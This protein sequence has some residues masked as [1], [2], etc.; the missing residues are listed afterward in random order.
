MGITTVGRRIRR[1]SGGITTKGSIGRSS[2]STAASI[3]ATALDHRKAR[4]LT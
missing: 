3:V 4:P 2:W 1:A